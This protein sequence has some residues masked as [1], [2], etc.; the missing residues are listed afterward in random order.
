[1]PSIDVITATMTLAAA[2][3]LSFYDALY[4]QLAHHLGLPL[5]TADN[6]LIARLRDSRIKPLYE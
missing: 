4:V 6:K 5:Y 3:G 2:K 1:M